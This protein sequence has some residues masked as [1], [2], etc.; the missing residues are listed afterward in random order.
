MMLANLLN[1]SEGGYCVWRQEAR[2]SPDSSLFVHNA[3]WAI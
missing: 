3:G 1:N 2:G